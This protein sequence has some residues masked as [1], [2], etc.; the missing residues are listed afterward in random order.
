MNYS[1]NCGGSEKKIDS[2]GLGVQEGFR[3]EVA[4]MDTMLGGGV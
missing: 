3:E 4:I 1:S 2:V